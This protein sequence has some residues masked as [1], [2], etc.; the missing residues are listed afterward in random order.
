MKN[1]VL[2][3]LVI[4]ASATGCTSSSSQVLTTASWKFDTV[5]ST[6]T[7]S[8]TPGGCP[9]GQFDTAAVISQSTDAAGNPTGSCTAAS[10]PSGSCYVDL[11]NCT[12]L[13]G[14]E[15]VDPGYYDQFVSITSHDGSQVYADGLPIN[16]DLTVDNAF[17]SDIIDN[18]GYFQVSW[19]LRTAAGA[20]AT[21]ADFVGEHG[22]ELASTISGSQNA[23]TDIWDCANGTDITDPLPEGA[24][25]VQ[26]NVL[27]STNP[28]TANSLGSSTA[29]N[30]SIAPQNV[31]KDLGTVTV[32]A[33]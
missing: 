15:L 14:T 6:G 22:V 12:D 7:L 10:T 21:C 5:S 2:G 29:M 31:V 17:T 18:G 19:D 27:D 3:S 20:P 23:L 9:G 26:L 24:Y 1:V 13:T 28:T 16:I 11:Y 8:P 4:I 33:N 30:A 25:V 32:T